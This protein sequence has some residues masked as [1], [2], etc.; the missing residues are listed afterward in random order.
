MLS[1]HIT[2]PEREHERAIAEQSPRMQ[3]PAMEA[4]ATAEAFESF[5]SAIEQV[6][7]SPHVL[8][9]AVALVASSRP[10]DA[11]ADEY[12]RNYVNWGASP[13]AAQ[14]LV[15]ASRASAV[16]DGRP[17]PEVRDVREMAVPVLR[18][19]ILPNYNALGE[20]IGAADIVEHLVG[21]VREPAV[22]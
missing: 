19:R 22:A 6:P 9:Y 21:A 11:A 7:V 3:I 12:V 2:Y 20:G 18:H 15:M 10:K 8:E 1:I 16:L 17:S 5:V 14:H 4:V 13:R